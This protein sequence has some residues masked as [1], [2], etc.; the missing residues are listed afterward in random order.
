[1][2]NFPF[3]NEK[4]RTGTFWNLKRDFSVIFSCSMKYWKQNIILAQEELI[5]KIFK[6]RTVT[7]Y[8][9]IDFIIFD[10]KIVIKPIIM[11]WR[12]ILSN[13]TATNKYL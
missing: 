12:N 4:A 11:I 9:I 10:L 7:V 6:G 5:P 2:L 13:A 1:M 8:I 3:K